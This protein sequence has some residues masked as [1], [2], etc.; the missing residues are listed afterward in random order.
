MTTLIKLILPVVFLG[1]LLQTCKDPPKM[2]PQKTIIKLD[3]TYVFPVKAIF[4]SLKLTTGDTAYIKDYITSQTDT[5]FYA[6]ITKQDRLRIDSLINTLNL[7]ALDTSYISNDF[8]GDGYNL[9]ISKNDTLKAINVHRGYEP[10]E[11]R[12]LSDHL[13]ELKTKLKLLPLDKNN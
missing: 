2:A 8:D 13:I 10:E 9:S 5:S 7:L 4:Y 12:R 1:F 11:L 6:I 3:F